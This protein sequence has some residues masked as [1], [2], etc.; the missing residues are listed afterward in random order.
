MSHRRP[1]TWT[2]FTDVFLAQ[3]N[4]PV[5]KAKQEQEQEWHG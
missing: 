1:Q 3:F 5:R 4:L 2:E